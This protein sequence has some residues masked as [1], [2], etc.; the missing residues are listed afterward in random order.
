[1]EMAY[2]IS[3]SFFLAIFCRK[4]FRSSQAVLT[5]ACLFCKIVTGFLLFLA[6]SYF[7]SCFGKAYINRVNLNRTV[8]G[9]CL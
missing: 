1:M 4:N 5:V 3:L 7:L 6:K 8:L 9:L 2:V